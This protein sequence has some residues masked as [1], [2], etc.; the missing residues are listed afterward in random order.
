MERNSSRRWPVREHWDVDRTGG[1]D[2]E[3]DGGFEPARPEILH[4]D[5]VEP[6]WRHLVAER[7][8][9]ERVQWRES[10]AFADR[11]HWH[12]DDEYARQSRTRDWLA[13]P[14]QYERRFETMGS[15]RASDHRDNGN[16]KPPE[17][18][19]NAPSQTPWRSSQRATASERAPMLKREGMKP[20]PNRARTNWPSREDSPRSERQARTQAP[21]RPNTGHPSYSFVGDP[22]CE[23]DVS[24]WAINEAPQLQIESNAPQAPRPRWRESNARRLHQRRWPES[25]T[26]DPPSSV[27][28][29]HWASTP[30]TEWQST[31]SSAVEQD[32]V[33]LNP[34]I[35][36]ESR[37]PN[38]SS[39]SAVERQRRKRRKC[40]VNQDSGSRLAALGLPAWAIAPATS[41]GPPSD[42]DTGGGGGE[43]LPVRL[44]YEQGFDAGDNDDESE[45]EDCDDSEFEPESKHQPRVCALRKTKA[46]AKR[47]A[48]MAAPAGVVVP[49]SG[50]R[51]QAGQQRNNGDDGSSKRRKGLCRFNGG[52]HNLVHSYGL[53]KT[54]GGGKRC[55]YA[56]GCHKATHSYGLCMA[57][58]GG[59]RC[60]HADGCG[61]GA[62][63]PTSY[64]VAHGGGERCEHAG[65]CGK[66][67]ISPT[68]F[69][70][71]HGGGRRCEH[72]GGCGKSAVGPTAYCIA[73]G[74]GK[75]CQHAGGCG[76]SAQWPT[77]YCKAHGGGKRCG[78]AGGCNKYVVRK[79]LCKQHGMAAGVC[80]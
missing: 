22:E 32:R 61:K 53:C 78:Y 25:S 74:G 26:E 49:G 59:K 20:W 7:R 38:D 67:A 63:S 19:D 36:G 42:D 40:S 54:H 80:D 76:K 79:G 51:K 5:G 45:D 68:S 9:T 34:D 2:D 17:Q 48:T 55:Q 46:R 65:G 58:G 33:V 52:C 11:P 64:C 57:H 73:H 50:K 30:S 60:Q 39:L 10:P 35:V 12:A 28:R 71:A 13:A 37:F 77:S 4:A 1:Y 69:C 47:S 62:A 6:N 14:R 15:A 70:V 31:R 8:R 29:R 23:G 18:L 75:R 27:R 56:G 44:S 21:C 72:A 41:N 43:S 24:E 16:Y 66:S 3:C